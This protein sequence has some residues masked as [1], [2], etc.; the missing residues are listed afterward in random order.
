MYTISFSQVCSLTS[1]DTWLAEERP[2]TAW[3]SHAS[4]SCITEQIGFCF[5]WF[6]C[7][8]KTW[9]I[10]FR[11]G[12][13]QF[14]YI[15]FAV[16][17]LMLLY[18]MSSVQQT[19]SS[20]GNSRQDRT[21]LLSGQY[22][23][24]NTRFCAAPADGSATT[25]VTNIRKK[26]QRWIFCETSLLKN[27]SLILLAKTT[28]FYIHLLRVDKFISSSRGVQ[29]NSSETIQHAGNVV[30]PQS[31]SALVSLIVLCSWYSPSCM[32][33]KKSSPTPNCICFIQKSKTMILKNTVVIVLS[34][35]LYSAQFNL[36]PK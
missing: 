26:L 4:S 15:S 25:S 34:I 9:A 3:S 6:I 20:L 22:P 11:Y 5:L 14:P 18:A 28:L 33:C 12:P 23:S 29:K 7:C 1:L 31:D 30:I 2:V 17:S 35:K 32:L 24:I 16:H 21:L 10:S 13:Y 27:S 36:R 8:Q 19:L